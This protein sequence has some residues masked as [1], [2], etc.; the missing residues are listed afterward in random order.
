MRKEWRVEPQAAEAAA[1]AQAVGVSPLVANMLV[2]R[3]V[4]TAAEAQAFL[5]PETQ[6]FHDALLLPDM[7]KAV[8]RIAAA[9]QGGERIVI[10]GDYD[11]DGITA[12]TLMLRNLHALG[13]QAD[14]YIPDRS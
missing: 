1:L 8:A 9:I 4:R 6:P 14:Y 3:G 7:A 2:Q 10:Y 13:A 12:T 5:H 11:V